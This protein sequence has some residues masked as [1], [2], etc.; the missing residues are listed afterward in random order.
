MVFLFVK[1]ENYEDNVIV[2]CLERIVLFVDILNINY[3]IFLIMFY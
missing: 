2:G 3:Y 1:Y